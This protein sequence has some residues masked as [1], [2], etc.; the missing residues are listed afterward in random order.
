MRSWQRKPNGERAALPFHTIDIHHAAVQGD[1][2]THD[3][4]PKTGPRYPPRIKVAAPVEPLEELAARVFRDANPLIAD[5][6]RGLVALLFNPDA[7][8]PA[9]GTVFDRVLHQIFKHLLQ[10]QRI[11]N[12]QKLRF[13]IITFDA[14][15]RGGQSCYIDHALRQRDK[16]DLLRLDAELPPMQARQVKQRIDQPLETLGLR[17]D[18]AQRILIAPV[19]MTFARGPHLQRLGVADNGR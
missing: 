9:G 17:G 8:L 11:A 12:D 19:Q 1:N 7:D 6:Q 2:F 10:P 16:I 3:R 5:G 14:V 18:H 15:A 13:R 4:K